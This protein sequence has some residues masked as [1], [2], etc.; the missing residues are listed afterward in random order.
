M[1]TGPDFDLSTA[2]R[3]FAAHCFNQAWDLIDKTGRTREDDRLMIALSHASLYHWLNRPDCSP[4]KLSVSYWQL[5]RIHALLGH[6]GEALRY[7]ED[8]LEYSQGLAPF[9]VGYAYEALA[10]AAVVAGAMDRAREFKQQAL[11]VAEQITNTDERDLLL[12]DL[13]QLP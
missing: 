12:A 6:T 7:A 5:S 1:S 3:F 9:Y 2:H 13:K 11:A 10:R 4:Q 8:C